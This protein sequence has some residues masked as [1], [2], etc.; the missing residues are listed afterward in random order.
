MTEWRNGGDGIEFRIEVCSIRA[1]F[2]TLTTM[3]H[4]GVV[5]QI[6]PAVI[7]FIDPINAKDQTLEIARMIVDFATNPFS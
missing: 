2:R 3:S 7:V 4:G 5:R 6:I 1:R